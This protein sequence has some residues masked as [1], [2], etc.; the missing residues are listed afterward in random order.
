MTVIDIT[1]YQ[2]CCT[3]KDYCDLHQLELI[4]LCNEGKRSKWGGFR[5]KRIGLM[6]GAADY[7]LPQGNATKKG[8]FLEVKTLK[9]KATTA[10]KSFIQ[11]VIN[12]GYA[13]EIAYGLD[14]AIN[15]IRNFYGL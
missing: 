8:L 7:F 6:P 11:M 5:L 2:I 15:I 13:G 1:E 14:A 9:G 3:I 4:H 10:Q 12:E